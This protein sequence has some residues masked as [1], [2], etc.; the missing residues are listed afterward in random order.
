MIGSARARPCP[1]CGSSNRGGRWCGVCGAD[2]TSGD[3][4]RPSGGEIPAP[5][6][7][8]RA[9]AAVAVLVAGGGALLLWPSS[10]DHDPDDL[11][12]EL[13][14]DGRADAA[15]GAASTPTCAAGPDCLRWQRPVTRGPFP[16]VAD[17]AISADLLLVAERAETTSEDEVIADVTAVDVGTG[18]EVWRQRVSAPPETIGPPGVQVAG[19]WAM[20]VDCAQLAALDL[21]SGEVVW[22]A[23]TDHPIALHGVAAAPSSH[24]EVVIA[25]TSRRDAPATGW[26]VIAMDVRDGA[27]RWRREVVTAAVVPDG[28]VVLTDAD[29]ILGLDPL[30]GE[31]RWEGTAR[32][33]DPA[34]RVVAGAVLEEDASAA[35]A[36]GS[37]LSAVDGRRL[38]DGI[39]VRHGPPALARTGSQ[40]RAEVV[41]TDDEIV[42]VEDGRVRWAIPQP[43]SGCCAGSHL[44]PHRITAELED[45]SFLVLDRDDGDT[46]RHE[47]GLHAEIG[48][49][50]ALVG[51]FVVSTDRPLR[52]R[53]MPLQVHEPDRNQLVATLPR[54]EILTILPD[55]EALFLVDEDVVRITGP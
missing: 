2:L 19:S 22:V 52:D 5:R 10:P 30:T 53:P 25:V 1:T 46:V 23:R 6:R 13:P 12:V 21:R 32:T 11:T 27:L 41:S 31:T 9:W 39:V 38:T 48:E 3:P 43:G 4:P 55:G 34:L 16:R 40:L 24:P 7:R 8:H 18:A 29:R 42:L 44:A 17:V 15:L 51:R 14:T 50:R 54:A 35:E 49:D 28:A 37:L 33:P 36:G 47:P 45:G 26:E 20:V